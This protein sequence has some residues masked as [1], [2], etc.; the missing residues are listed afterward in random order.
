MKYRCVQAIIVCVMLLFGT[1]IAQARVSVTKPAQPTAARAPGIKNAGECPNTPGR[2]N[3]FIL[4]VK[5]W[6]GRK[7]ILLPKQKIVQAFGYG[8]YLAPELDRSK[9]AV[10][11]ARETKERRIRCDVFGQGS[12]VAHDVKPLGDEYLVRFKHEPSGVSLFAKT[13]KGTVEGLALAD[14]I[15]KARKRWLGVAVYS[16]RRF[17]NKYDSATGN[18]STMK[19]KL[20]DPLRVHDVRWGTTPLPSQPLWLMVET[21]QGERG[22][23]T[24]RVSWT[25]VLSDKIAEGRPWD[26]D[27]LEQD[28]KKL[29]AWDN[30]I[31][32]AIDNHAIVAGMTKAQVRLSWGAPGAMRT[33]SAGGP[34]KDYWLYDDGQQ[35]QFIGDS[36]ATQ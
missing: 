2:D 28:P 21:Q 36:L 8:L 29:Y 18:V 16:V 1:S 33:D 13:R 20:R 24:V 35:L 7:F 19:V 31:W 30:V 34:V 15:D 17:I 3:E 12:L 27:I 26:D 32:E 22:F 4:P 5:R 10:N 11:P 25:N 14:D 6:P 23:I 9:N